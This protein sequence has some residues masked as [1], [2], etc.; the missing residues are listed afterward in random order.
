MTDI[1]LMQLRHIFKLEQFHVKPRL[2]YSRKGR[3]AVIHR[4]SVQ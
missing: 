1:P 3:L 2:I 4:H